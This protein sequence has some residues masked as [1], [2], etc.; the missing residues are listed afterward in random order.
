MKAKLLCAVALAAVM[1]LPSI[2]QAN[3]LSNAGFETWVM[4]GGEEVPADWWHMFSDPDITGSKESTIVKS[5]SYSGKTQATGSG[6]GGWGQRQPF[7]ANDTVY[8]YQPVNIPIAL[9]N[10]LATLEIAFESAPDVTIGSAVKTSM[11]AATSGW[12]ALQYSAVAPTGTNYVK[13]TV[14]LETW[15]EG[16]FTGAAYFDDAYADSVPVPEPSTLLLLGS[17]LVG[18]MAFIKRKRS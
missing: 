9:G 11:S 13:Y 18:L 4:Y 16:P 17:G 10:A 5:G 14:L 2:A 15:G 3:L 12:E 7:A 6:W 1:A 8:A